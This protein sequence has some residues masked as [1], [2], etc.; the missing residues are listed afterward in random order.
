MIRII[1]SR[2]RLSLA[3]LA[4][5]TT[6]AC[7]GKSDTAPPITQRQRDSAI[8]ASS[9]PGAQGVRGA[10]SA[11]D[12]AARRKAVLDSIARADSGH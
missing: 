4:I 1:H 11:Q 9:L 2:V 5:A 6:A 3:A 12:S 8:G 7:G 10:L